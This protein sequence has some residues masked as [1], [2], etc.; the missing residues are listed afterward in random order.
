MARGLLTY[1]LVSMGFAGPKRSLLMRFNW[2][3]HVMLL[4]I[5]WAAGLPV[6]R[7]IMGFKTRAADIF[8]G[9][10]L[11]SCFNLESFV[12]AN[13]LQLI[14]IVLG[15][16]FVWADV[17]LYCFCVF[18]LRIT[19][20]NCQILAPKSLTISP[21]CTYKE[22]KTPTHAHTQFKQINK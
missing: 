5:D 15:N 3:P 11:G 10:F 16:V 12:L 4:R 17:F 9:V 19:I 1:L 8:L 20:E 2:R 18:S 7:Q 13:F 6:T 14:L 21:T 22:E